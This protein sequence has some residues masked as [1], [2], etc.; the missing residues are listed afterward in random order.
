MS[1]KQRGGTFVVDCDAPG[2]HRNEESDEAETFSDAAREFRA[3]GWRAVN[4][5]GKWLNYCPACKQK[6]GD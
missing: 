6:L 1:I 4:S 5:S 2:C 3:L